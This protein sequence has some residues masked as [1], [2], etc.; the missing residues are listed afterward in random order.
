MW[1]TTYKFVCPQS[2]IRIRISLA[3]SRVSSRLPPNKA[4]TLMLRIDTYELPHTNSYV[5]NQSY[6]F[7]FHL[8]S[9]LQ[10]PN[11]K[12]RTFGNWWW[13][14]SPNKV[15]SLMLQ[16][17]TCELSHTNLYVI[18]QSYEFVFY[19]HPLVSPHVCLQIRRRHWCYELIH[20][21]YHI[22]ICMWSINH[23]NSY[24]ISLPRFSLQIRG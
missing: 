1:V 8:T 16:I 3:S 22:Q 6:E 9:S 10:P 18:N 14:R 21:S 23:T 17:D 19:L 5:V 12:V 11:K 4:P 20:V 7:V 15:P 2:I 13:W 24:F